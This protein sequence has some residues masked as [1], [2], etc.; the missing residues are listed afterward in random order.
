MPSEQYKKLI[1]DAFINNRV[2]HGERQRLLENLELY[3]ENAVV[4]VRAMELA[5]ENSNFYSSIPESK[6]SLAA[7][8]TANV[9]ND[10]NVSKDFL[11]SFAVNKPETTSCVSKVCS[12]CEQAY[13]LRNWCPARNA[14]TCYKFQKKTHFANVCWSKP[15]KN[16]N[17]S[18]FSSMLCVVH[19]TSDC[20]TR[21]SLIG[22]IMD[23]KV[24]ASIDTSRLMSQ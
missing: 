2:S 15:T 12:F 19:E 16:T 20:L 22:Q 4:K 3:L 7:S 14:S 8:A 23:T 5:Q 17:A 9:C 6:I 21:A 10:E 13:H 11:L 18:M 1:L 24:F